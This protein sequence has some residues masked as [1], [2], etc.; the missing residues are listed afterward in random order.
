MLAKPVLVKALSHFW[1][2]GNLAKLM[3]NLIQK[4]ESNSILEAIFMNIFDLKEYA[5]M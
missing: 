2:V 3:S 1:I 5:N 4:I